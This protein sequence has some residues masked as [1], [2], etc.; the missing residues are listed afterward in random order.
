M[1]DR[2]LPTNA[3]EGRTPY[4]SVLLVIVVAGAIV[5]LFLISVFVFHGEKS[6]DANKAQPNIETPT[7]GETKQP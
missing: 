5:L 2:P 7:T 3:R 6:A 1:S 4:D